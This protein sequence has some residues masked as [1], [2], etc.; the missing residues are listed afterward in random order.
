MPALDWLVSLT[1]DD[2]RRIFRASPVK[3][4]KWRGLLRSACVALGSSAIAPENP[5]YP[6]I[7]QRLEELASA[8]DAILA[9]HAA[10]ALARLHSA[11]SAQIPRDRDSHGA[12]KHS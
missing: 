2:F 6:R 7:V 5:A 12:A 8:E 4:A 9:E 10:W 11:S 3:R 1:E